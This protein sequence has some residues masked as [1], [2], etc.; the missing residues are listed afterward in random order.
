MVTLVSIDE[1]RALS[2]APIALISDDSLKV[3]I[4]NFETLIK[5]TYQVEYTPVVKIETLTG[6]SKSQIVLEEYN[7]LTV[8]ELRNGTTV[9][10]A[11]NIFVHSDKGMIELH[12][13]TATNQFLYRFWDYPLNVKIKYLYGMIEKDNVKQTEGTGTITAGTSVVVPVLASSSFAVNDWAYLEDL[14]GQWEV[15]QITAKDTVGTDLTFAKLVN[16]Y[17]TATLIVGSKTNEVVRQYVL[18]ECA[19]ATAINAIG[20][21][22]TIATGYSMEGVNVQVGVPYTHW[23]NNLDAN[24]KQRDMWLSRLKKLLS[25]II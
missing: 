15:A 8:Y 13:V 5:S 3:L 10:S 9:L 22:Y 16:S 20:S 7:P 19:I 2:G 25:T 6:E 24:M 12:G 21:T 11:A 14:N 23:K 4:D 1:V 18:Y 17:E